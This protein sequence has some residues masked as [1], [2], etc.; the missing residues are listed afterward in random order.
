MA[1]FSHGHIVLAFMVNF[2]GLK[3]L[4]IPMFVD[5][6]SR[7][8]NP[9]QA[10]FISHGSIRYLSGRLALSVSGL[11]FYSILS[12]F[13]LPTSSTASKVRPFE[14]STTST[15]TAIYNPNDDVFTTSRFLGSSIE[16]LSPSR[17]TNSQTSKTYKQ[18]RD[19]FLTRRLPEA[20]S[21]IRSLVNVPTVSDESP[22]NDRPRNAP[23]AAAS[24]NQRIKIWSLYLTLLN[25]IQELGPQEGGAQFGNKEWTRLT[26]KASDSSIWSEVVRTG[27]GGVEGNVDA[28]VVVN[29][30]AVGTLSYV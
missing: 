22:D 19:L 28:D 21:T 26:S 3:T 15:D 10:N 13:Y 30:Y 14:M 12:P 5:D 1:S 25:A 17:N 7:S 16:P 18:A 27:Y 9:G 20:Y 2:S 6:A 8:D 4:R 24:R 11:P 29:L 23:V